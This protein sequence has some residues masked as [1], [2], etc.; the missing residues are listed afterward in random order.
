VTEESF[1]GMDSLIQEVRNAYV[2]NIDRINDVPQTVSVSDT[3]ASKIVLGIYGIV[4]AYDRYFITGI[5]M[6][7]LKNISFTESSLKQFV[8]FYSDFKEEFNKCKV[9]FREQGIT[10]TPMKLI[11]MY[12]W[13]VGFMM[14]NPSNYSENELQAIIEFAESNIQD[15]TESNIRVPTEKKERKIINPGL[16]EDIRQFIYNVLQEALIDEI[17]YIDLTSGKIHKDMNL[18]N[19]F[20]PVC[21]AM[22]SI[23][24]TRFEIIQ[25]TPSGMSST[26]KVRYW[27]K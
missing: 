5:K 25:D 13:Q 18:N 1:I 21:N 10:Y 15:F 22:T 23:H 27:L 12:F 11:D 24:N 2:D 14:D 16:T 8:Y 17:P 4:P 9:L 19:R 7:G 26:K 3:L 20:A 6:H